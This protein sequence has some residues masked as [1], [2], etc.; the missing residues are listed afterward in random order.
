[1]DLL[2]YK[3]LYWPILMAISISKPISDYFWLREFSNE[4]GA[5]YSIKVLLIL[6]ISKKYTYMIACGLV[7]WLGTFL[8]L[9]L[10]PDLSVI[11][12][13]LFVLL[14]TVLFM[15]VTI[16]NIKSILVIGLI[17]VTFANFLLIQLFMPLTQVTDLETLNNL[18]SNLISTFNYVT[19]AT[20]TVGLVWQFGRHH[21]E[22]VY[23]TISTMFYA[24]GYILLN[25][26]IS[27]IQL[28]LPTI[29]SIIKLA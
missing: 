25:M 1:M 13:V 29:Q 11:H 8:W 22:N 21:K 5:I 19:I 2:L 15:A 24:I 20:A 4:N 18:L 12:G 16:I 3:T 14:L 28:F 10:L 23:G 26:L 7:F 17:I 9:K 27:F 6:L